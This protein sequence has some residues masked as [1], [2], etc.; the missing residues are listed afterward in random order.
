MRVAEPV[1]AGAWLMLPPFAHGHFFDPAPLEIGLGLAPTPR[2]CGAEGLAMG[3]GCASVDDDRLLIESV[4]APTYWSLAGDRIQWSSPLEPM[5]R[6][7]VPGLT[8]STDVL[9]SVT[10]ATAAGHLWEAQF[11]AHTGS[12][13]AHVVINE[14]FANPKGPEPEQEWIE[15]YNDGLLETSLAGWVLEDEG[16]SIPL[17]D[18]VLGPGAFALL[19]RSDFDLLCPA[20]IAPDDQAVIVRVEQ[21]GKNGISNSG[22]ALTLRSSA[23]ALVSQFPAIPAS[24]AGVSIARRQPWLPDDEA[25]FGLHAADGASPGSH[26]E[27]E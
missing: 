12:V 24:K 15:L 26:N 22:E 17:G 8:P 3:P 19:V 4:G 9:L 2:R 16:S 6:A 7:V 25:S 23:G 11:S 20:D 27:V 21:L 18:A 5:G 14:V 1:E 13:R 10:V